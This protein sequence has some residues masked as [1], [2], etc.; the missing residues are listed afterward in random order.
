ML[1]SLFN[2]FAIGVLALPTIAA[3]TPS[4]NSNDLQSRQATEIVSAVID[5]ASFAN[6]VY[7]EVQDLIDNGHDGASKFV[8]DTV[9][10]YAA[11]FPDKNIIMYHDQDSSWNFAG[12]SHVHTEFNLPDPLG[13]MVYEIIVFDYGSFRRRGDGGYL[14]WGF[15]GNWVTTSTDGKSLYFDPN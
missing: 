10:R 14:N 5:I 7:N 13:T 12:A 9:S 1:F 15:Q 3:P 11:Q 4:Q 8:Q 2:A 6:D